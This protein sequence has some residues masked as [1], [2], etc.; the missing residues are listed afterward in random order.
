M[1]RT[2]ACVALGLLAG[3]AAGC[4][5]RDG[6]AAAPVSP[7]A[8]RSTA[9][10]SP[11]PTEVPPV[12]KVPGRDGQAPPQQVF[13]ERQLKR[14][15]LSP[16]AFGKGTERI[17]AH[18][19]PFEDTPAQRDGTWTDCRSA[20]KD[21][22][23]LGTA[24]YRGTAV[25]GVM[26]RVDRTKRPPRGHRVAGQMLKSLTVAAARDSH[27]LDLAILGHCRSY[28][29]DADAGTAHWTRRTRPLADLGD[30]AYLE[31][32]RLR[33]GN[34]EFTTFIVHAR[35][36]GVLITF[37]GGEDATEEQTVS[38]ASRLAEHAGRTL[39]DVSP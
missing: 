4:G 29:G 36:G 2:A 28:A 21:A 16:A 27:R 18:E 39:Y 15:L 8:S 19:G 35:V 1:R 23:W 33:N 9:A 20:D 14:A 10:A 3:L 11:S 31:T 30:E 13:T 25:S 34:E 17:E 12:V 24:T 26:M 22:S 37:T 38:A 6:E 7:S 32:S 5:G